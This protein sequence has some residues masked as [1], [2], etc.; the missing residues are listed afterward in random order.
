ML[1]DETG[2]EVR[3]EGH[4][5]IVTDQDGHTFKAEIIDQAETMAKK[6]AAKK[7]TSPAKSDRWAMLNTMVDMAIRDLTAAEIKVWLVL[8]RDVRNGL[9]RTSMA[10]IARRAG[11]EPRSAKRAMRS[12][13]ARRLVKIVAHGTID[14]KPNT[15][16]LKMPT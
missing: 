12:L 5:A 14:G 2:V 10:D 3:I 1:P 9:A 15:Y 4:E 8:F 6:R 13:E 7:S 11:L 16:Q